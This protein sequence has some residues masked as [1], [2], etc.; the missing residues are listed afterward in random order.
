MHHGNPILTHAQQ[1]D[2]IR[3]W[4]ITYSVGLPLTFDDQEIPTHLSINGNAEL[5]GLK[6]VLCT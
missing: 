6:K 5:P 3:H 1:C 2:V 4:E